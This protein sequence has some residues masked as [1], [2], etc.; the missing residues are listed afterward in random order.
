MKTGGEDS[1]RFCVLRIPECFCI[2]ALY[3]FTVKFGING[4]EYSSGIMATGKSFF[5][6]R[7]RK[8][9]PDREEECYGEKGKGD[10]SG[11]I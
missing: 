11:H 10:Y 3:G 9:E 1:G 2:R 8:N 4:V 6:E 5:E 7:Q